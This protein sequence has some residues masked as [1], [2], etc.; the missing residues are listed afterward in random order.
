M[1]SLPNNLFNESLVHCTY[2]IPKTKIAINKKSKQVE[3][4]ITLWRK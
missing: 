1:A 2:D 4:S 3:K